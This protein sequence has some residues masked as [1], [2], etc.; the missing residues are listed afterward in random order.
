MM[1][2]RPATTDSPTSVG[3]EVGA[4]TTQGTTAAVAV[5]PDDANVEGTTAARDMTE[6]TAPTDAVRNGTGEM[7][8]VADGSGSGRGMPL[9]ASSSSSPLPL[10]LL[11][12]AREQLA[13]A[14]SSLTGANQ[15]NAEVCIVPLYRIKR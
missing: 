10:A 14:A 8:S 6:N 13:D 12:H 4:D 11:L 15:E 9:K 1:E 5:P 7:R 3:T 2:P